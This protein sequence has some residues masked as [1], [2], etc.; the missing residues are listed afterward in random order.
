MVQNTWM[1]WKTTIVGILLA[2]PQIITALGAQHVALGKW[3]ALAT[4]FAT[5]V[6]GA[7]ARDPGSGTITTTSTKVL[8]WLALA[9]LALVL[10]GCPAQQRQQVAQALQTASTVVQSFQQAEIVSHNQGVI[11]DDDHHFIEQQ[12]LTIAGAGKS[13][14]TC[15]KTTTTVAGDIA[16][17]NTMVTMVDQVNSQGGTYIKSAQAKQDFTL[18]MT[19]L[20]AALQTVTAILGG[21]ATK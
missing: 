11:S 14:D 17:V 6:L 20:K 5:L 2:V 19:G 15:V 13:A 4:G 12:L 18:A 21:G 10:I 7:V 1:H 3:G 16:C 9:P 8:A